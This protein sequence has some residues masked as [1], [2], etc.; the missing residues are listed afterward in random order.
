MQLR[1][2]PFVRIQQGKKL[3]ELR[4]WDEKRRRLR[5][6]DQIA[7][8]KLPELKQKIKVQVTALLIYETF[9]ELMT[10]LPVR[11]LGYTEA[12]REYLKTCM[13]EYYTSQEEKKWGVVSIKFKIL[14]KAG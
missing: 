9:A 7:F 10:D 2:E 1:A 14:E 5:L 8:S 3:V 6:G 11:L 4:L 12:D 13:R